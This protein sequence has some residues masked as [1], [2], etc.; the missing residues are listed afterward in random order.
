M[1][2]LAQAISGALVQFVW[3]GFLIAFA[4]SV[5]LFLLRGSDPRIRYLISCG[6][7]LVLAV[8]P[9]ATAIALYDPLASN[10]PGPAALTLTIRAVWNHTAAGVPNFMSSLN[11]AQPWILRF[12]ILGVTLLSMRL[13]YL[14]L[15]VSALR[16]S[17]TPPDSLTLAIANALARRMGMRR[18]VRV[19]I[20]AIP[21]GPGVAG[22]FR[23]V[24]LLPTAT[25]LHL[26]T[27]QLEAILAHEIAHLRRY[28][29]VVNLVQSIVETLLFYHPA[30][31]W[32]SNR[33]R[34]EREL[35]CDD[36]AVR[37]SGNALCYARALTALE[38]MRVESPAFAL[39]ALGTRVSPLEY[40]IRRVVEPAG[41]A[42]RLSVLPGFLALA[43]TLLCVFIYSGP[44]HG[45]NVPRP[46]LVEY[47]EYARENGIQ[48]TVPVQVEIDRVGGVSDAKAM[49][50]PKELRQ[51][52]VKS[53]TTLHFAPEP[54]ETTE[55]VNVAFKLDSPAIT[56][57]APPVPVPS[58]APTT[59]HIG[60]AWR[61]QGEYVIGT[62]ASREK[63]PAKQL[64]LVKEWERQYPSTEL[65]TQRTILKSR[66]LVAVLQS[67]WGKTD[68]AILEPARAAGLELAG[69]LGEYFSED[70]R[71]S[72]ESLD[73]WAQ[74]RWNSE[75]QLH[76]ALAYIAQVEKDDA[77]AEI[78]LRKVLTVDPDEAGT[79]YELGAVIL[80]EMAADN[81][82][83]RYSEAIY[84]FARSLTVTGPNAL[85]PE[86]KTLA[87]DAL[88]RSY[89]SYH[90]STDGMDDL[91]MQVS[92]S[93]LPPADFHIMS[94]DELNQ[95][96][97][98]TRPDL[99][100][101]RNAKTALLEKGDRQFAVIK[102]MA[103][104]VTFHAT[105]VSQISPNRIVVNI[106]DAPAGDAILRLDAVNFAAIRP[107][108]ELD[109]RGYP[110][111]WTREPYT[112]TFVIRN[113]VTDVVGLNTKPAHKNL[114]ARAFKGLFHVLRHL[115]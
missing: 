3:Q 16:R 21:G 38:R 110:D 86:Q 49:G 45:T 69:N 47:P 4:L 10:A 72:G 1:S 52:A 80:R 53:A 75:V 68:P 31:W 30:V 34:H 48:G 108:A 91:M 115:A 99:E 66:A 88:K 9:V 59:L 6:A 22:W 50:G 113:P 111:S 114:I 51:A 92:A 26:T 36:L 41:A 78:E 55:R 20:S 17:G 32:L 27:D 93:A 63:D 56:P 109:F 57:P 40:R 89:G 76:Q 98:D 82:L 28:D 104:P 65:K 106:D 64:E 107:G 112:M 14:S 12:W 18:A 95:Y 101:W 84:D 103:I 23:P 61:D 90:G 7:L 46:S 29:D 15:R 70:L 94:V 87:E 13:A 67:V 54:K 37:A 74:E 85:P 2:P 83:S 100:F 102:D 58:P 60:P 11:A 105:V 44:L 5:V 8:L 62:A 71:P 77:T 42:H 35:C 25:I 33:I 81:Q 73:Q 96:V 43:M 19:L 39:G 97:K 24:I 79:S